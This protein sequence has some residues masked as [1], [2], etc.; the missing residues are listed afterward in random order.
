MD[1]NIA[2]P[3]AGRQRRRHS[4]EFRASV[5]Q[6]CLQ[7][8][9]SIAAVALANGLN[10]NMVRK[11]VINAQTPSLPTSADRARSR[12]LSVP[13]HSLPSAPAFVPLALPAPSAAPVGIQIDLSTPAGVSIKMT[14]PTSAA[15]QCVTWL[16]EWLR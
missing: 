6:A 8:G 7:P 10:A 14:W 13:D 11:W 15:E 5:I 2:H 9:V 16:R 1:T 3:P 4:P 12:F